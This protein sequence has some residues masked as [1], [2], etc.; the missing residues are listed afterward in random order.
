MDLVETNGSNANME[1]DPS[2]VI[3]LPASIEPLVEHFNQHEDKLRFA[4]LMSPT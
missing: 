1:G 2:L 4:A 3:S